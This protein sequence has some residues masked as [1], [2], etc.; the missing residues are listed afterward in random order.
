MVVGV[1]GP[2]VELG[3]EDLAAAEREQRV[4]E[5][6]GRINQ[7]HVELVAIEP[8]LVPTTTR[9]PRPQLS[10]ARMTRGWGRSGRG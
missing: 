4:A 2:P 3:Q 9:G 8:T 10:P 6:V 7:G 5:T 1:L